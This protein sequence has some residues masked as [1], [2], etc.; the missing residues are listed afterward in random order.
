MQITIEVAERGSKQEKY[1]GALKQLCGELCEG[2]TDEA[3]MIQ[4]LNMTS[5]LIV[6]ELRVDIRRLEDEVAAHAVIA[7]PK[8]YVSMGYGRKNRNHR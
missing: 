5:S 8:P 6:N 1:I 4:A 3:R 2:S 7:N